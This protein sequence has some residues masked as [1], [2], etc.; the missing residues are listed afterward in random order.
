MTTESP[1]IQT[2][3]ICGT[4]I[5]YLEQ[6]SG[7]P[8]V[9]VHG[10][11]SDHRIW[12][13]QRPAVSSRYRYIALDM[14]YFGT[15]PWPD[16]AVHFSPQQH[17]ADLA[18]FIEALGMGPAHL[19]GRSYGS[20]IALAT[21]VHHP[22]L[23]RSLFLNEP[24]V[25]SLVVDPRDR[26]ILVGELESFK[27]LGETAKKLA[28]PEATALFCEWVNDQPGAFDALPATTKT[29]S[30]DNARTVAAQLAAPL[31]MIE[32]AAVA[33]LTI[34]VTV[35]CG[36]QTRPF[37]E[38]LARALKNAAPKAELIVLPGAKHGAPNEQPEAF[39]AAL[40]DFL[41]ACAN[42]A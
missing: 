32:R 42:A 30:L 7:E 3:R 9:F 8:V 12:E 21:A 33:E 29:I 16:D 34:P 6:G 10:S 37:F 31:M 25:P 20:A 39:N 13:N 15:L 41:S 11:L 26:Q 19:V 5:S 14:R 24:P 28:P 1:T 23:V 40:M 2:A 22:H 4:E 36:A 17:T 27:Q 18:A 38:V 35:M